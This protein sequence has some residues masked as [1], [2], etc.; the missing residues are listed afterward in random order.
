MKKDITNN[1]LAVMV[2]NGFSSVDKRFDSV[3]KRFDAV[4]KRF[5]KVENRLTNV[6]EAIKSTRQDVLKIG[7]R[8]VPRYEFD[9]LLSRV[10]RIEQRL[11]GKHK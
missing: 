11:E 10:G 4:D 6:E 7:D 9:T 8:F 5:D 1:D 2:A 3:D